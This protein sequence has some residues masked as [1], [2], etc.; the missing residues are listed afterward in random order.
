M[1][2]RLHNNRPSRKKAALSDSGASGI[3]KKPS[4]HARRRFY[5]FK[6]APRCRPPLIFHPPLRQVGALRNPYCLP[7]ACLSTGAWHPASDAD[8]CCENVGKNKQ[9]A[10]TS[11]MSFQTVLSLYRTASVPVKAY[12]RPFLPSSHAQQRSPS[13]PFSA[14]PVTQCRRTVRAPFPYRATASQFV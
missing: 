11:G 4:A 5:M 6:K 3:S 7:L 14:I 8:S 12:S 13:P 2:I 1:S 10:H 9:L